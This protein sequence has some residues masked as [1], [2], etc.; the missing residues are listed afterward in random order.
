MLAALVGVHR[1]GR[2]QDE[3]LTVELG[4]HPA[5]GAER[6][7]AAPDDDVEDL[8]ERLRR[9]QAPG[10]LDEPVEAQRRD[11]LLGERVAQLVTAQVEV[12]DGA[13]LG[14]GVRAGVG[15]GPGA[16]EGLRVGGDVLDAVGQ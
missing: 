11:G 4:D 15:G 6:L 14:P 12:Q 2:G 1:R 13:A 10:H 9:S 16:D 8:L 3:H 7:Q 5:L